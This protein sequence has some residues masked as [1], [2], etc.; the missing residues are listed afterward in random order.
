M[1][2]PDGALPAGSL[3][4]GLFA[5]AQAQ[6]AEEAKRAA[7]GGALGGFEDAQ[8]SYWGFESDVAGIAEQLRDE[9]LDL[10][11]RVDLLEGVNGYCNTFMSAN[12]LVAQNQL[13]ALPFD[14]QLGPNI[15][16][17]PFDGGIRLLTKGLWRA[18]AI[19]TCDKMT[20]SNFSAQVYITVLQ[21]TTGAVYSDTRYDIVLTP[22]GS[23]SAAFSKTFVIPTADAYMVKARIQHNRTARLRVFGG[24]LRSALSV[25]KWSNNTE[26]NVEIQDPPDGGDLG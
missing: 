18:D 8:E 9:Q 7:T 16:A 5:A 21:I 10:N 24:T 26:H 15:G 22:S 6:T 20:S 11:D 23:E 13:L 4:P 17:I 19:V 25:N 14:T 12:W 3:A 1:T 2:S